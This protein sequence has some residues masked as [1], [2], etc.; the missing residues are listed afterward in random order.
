MTFFQDLEADNCD[1]ESLPKNLSIRS[2]ELLEW[3]N[4]IRQ[5]SSFASTPMGKR[6]ILNFQIPLTKEESEEEE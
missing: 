6:A 1:K 5:L 4:L 2:L 3:P